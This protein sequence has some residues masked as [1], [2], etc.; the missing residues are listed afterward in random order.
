MKVLVTGGA[1]FIGSHLV[2]ILLER[3]A[4][5][6]A[7]DNLAAGRRENVADLVGDPR[8]RLDVGDITDAGWLRQAIRDTDPDIVFHLAALHFIPYC[9]EHPV[10]T[11]HVNVVGTETVLQAIRGSGVQRFVFM[12]TGDVY[13]PSEAPHGEEDRTAPFNVYGRS[14]LFGEELV[15][16]AA[17]QQP[18]VGFTIV[19]CFN[20]FGPRE[21]NPHLIPHV[22]SEL[23]AGRAI[24]LGNLWP[25]RD[26]VFVC[27]V[28]RA[29]CALAFD[30]ERGPVDIFNV[31]S[32]RGHSVEELLAAIS[33]VTGRRLEVR[34]EADRMRSIE[35]G[36]LVANVEKIRKR[37]GWTAQTDLRHGLRLTLAASSVPLV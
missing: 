28:A 31:G 11:L 34:Q 18:G 36:A 20:A 1:G 21:T 25:R 26:Y 33:D 17:V 30:S 10:E 12:S 24:R 27:D 2:E 32:G 5:V 29:L 35:R 23:G 14:K 9:I 13:E 6:C 3:K 4:R 19:R 37:T 8:F 15:R 16:A 22:V 7:V